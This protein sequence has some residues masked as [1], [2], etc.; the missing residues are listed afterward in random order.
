MSC[1]VS[2]FGALLI[3]CANTASA[4]PCADTALVLAIDGSGSVGNAEFALQMQATALALTDPEVIGAIQAVG[5]IAIAAV[6]WGDTAYGAQITDWHLVRDMQEAQVFAAELAGQPRLMSGSTDLGNGIDLALDLL[7][8]PQNCATRR[9]IDVSGDGRESLHSRFRHTSL[10]EAR[11]QAGAMGVQINGLAVATND[12]KLAEYY[13]SQV[14]LGEGA[15]VIS[16]TG[17]ASFKEAMTRKL[18][19]EIGEHLLLAQLSDKW[20]SPGA[21]PDPD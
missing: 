13:A 5:G 7:D 21:D 6:V 3:C 10:S 18:V 20:A 4:M 8:T 17:Y 14:I 19:R 9:L 11:E 12:P 2:T 16:V 1:S 15:F